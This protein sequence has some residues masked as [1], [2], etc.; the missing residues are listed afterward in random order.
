MPGHA[1]GRGKPPAG[2]RDVF[3]NALAEC[4]NVTRA[5]AEADVPKQ[6]AY[7][8]R[9]TSAKFA[10]Q[11]DEALRQGVDALEGEALRRAQFGTE[12]PVFQGGVLVGHVTE[13]SDTLMMFLLKA[14]NPEKFGDKQRHE[15][16]GADGGAL[17]L[18]WIG[19]LTERFDGDDGDSE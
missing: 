13:Y 8:A 9:S 19:G 15:V 16:T 17:Q 7:R 6:T 5:A 14:H 2:W 1:T 12:K 4:P 10:E 11:W 18:T 3:L